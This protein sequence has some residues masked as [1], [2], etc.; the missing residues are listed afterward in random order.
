MDRFGDLKENTSFAHDVFSEVALGAA[1]VNVQFP[2]QPDVEQRNTIGIAV[3]THRRELA[4]ESALQ[5]FV[6]PLLG[7]RPAGPTQFGRTHADLRELSPEERNPAIA[8]ALIALRLALAWS[9]L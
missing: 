8:S 4:A 7:H 2:V 3:L 1:G 5:H 6:C 9:A